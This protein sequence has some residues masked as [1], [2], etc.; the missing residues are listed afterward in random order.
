M[1]KILATDEQIDEMLIAGHSFREIQSRLTVGDRRMTSRRKILKEQGKFK[2]VEPTPPETA[3]ERHDRIRQLKMERDLLNEVQGERSFRKWL[4][5][6]LDEHVRDPI[7]K[8]PTPNQKRSKNAHERFAYLGL[9]DWHFEENVKPEGVLGLNSYSIEIACRRVWRVI[10]SVREWKRDF[11]HGGR[12]VVPELVVGLN[13]DFLTGTLHGAERHTDSPNVVRAALACGDLVA[14]ALRD[15]AADFPKVRVIGTVGNHGRLPDQKRVP[16]KDP[17]RSW[18]YLAYG[19]AKRWLAGQRHV[20]F[21]L[22]EAYGVL[23]EVGG[24]L[25][26]QSHGNFISNQLGIVNYGVRRFASNLAANI[27]AAQES[28]KKQLR[29]AF[30]GH[31]H[32]SNSSEFAGIEAFI[33]PSLIGTQEYSFLGGGSVS[34]S[35]QKMFIFDEK[36]GHVSQETFYG[37]GGGSKGTYELE[38]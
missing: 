28:F 4:H 34:K 20:E 35:A 10:Q 17:T 15:L 27:I 6:I 32:A 14:M 21:Y 38:V 2:G 24:H 19:I 11:E 37:E 31:W 12:Y 29:Y 16:T 25:C 23:F 3:Q 5:E 7:P 26:Y 22:P 18:D 36:L 13:G 30:F 8:L 9:N 33:C 1:A